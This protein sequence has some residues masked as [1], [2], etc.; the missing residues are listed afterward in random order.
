MHVDRARAQH[1]LT[2]DLAVR[3]AR[4]H[5]AHHL[6]LA[7]RQAGVLVVGGRT[8]AEP[9]LDR[10]AEPRELVGGLGRQRRGAEPAGR[11]VRLH[12]PLDR[13]LALPRRGERDTGAELDL[14]SLE[15]DLEAGVQLGRAV[16]LLGGGVGM[17]F[18]ERRLAERVRQRGQGVRVARRGHDARERLGTG[19][20]VVEPAVAGEKA[21]GPAQAPDR[22]VVI[23]AAR[24]ALHHEAAVTAGLVEV[25]LVL[26]EHRE[27]GGAV[28]GHRDHVEAGGRLEALDEQRPG[29]R[30][31]AAEGPDR[32]EHAVHHQ[33]RVRA[34]A[35]GA[36]LLRQL[37]RA[38][39]VAQLAQHVGH[40]AQAG[41]LRARGA[42]RLTEADRGGERRA[43][44]AVVAGDL[45]GRA[46][47]LVDLGRLERELVLERER[48]P[49]SDRVHPLAELAALHARDALEPEAPRPQVECAPRARPRRAPGG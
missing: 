37:D 7:A 27:R 22:V 45:V 14:G 24:P 43:R 42:A 26:V 18:G 48:E 5:Q 1:E 25:A 17:A 16:D 6:E 40:A 20:R 4:G 35:R 46:E 28:D 9:A 10:L 47:P 49:C 34:G 13:R 39:P 32:P 31:L 2:G 44:A 29:G 33:R 30:S 38:L 11:A 8:P 41:V 36:Q 12:Q 21:R 3:A 15:R 23:L 19:A